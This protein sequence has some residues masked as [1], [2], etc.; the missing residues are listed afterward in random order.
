MN[1]RNVTLAAAMSAV[2]GFSP[3]AARAESTQGEIKWFGSIYAKFLDGNRRTESGLG[4]IV[5]SAFYNLRDERSTGLG[6]DVGAKVKLPTADEATASEDTPTA[7][8]APASEDAPAVAEAPVADES[9]AADETP[10]Q[11]PTAETPSADE[12]PESAPSS[13]EAASDEEA[14]GS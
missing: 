8:E 5:A 3:T 13:D 11:A 9:N 6:I 10:E 14:P 12:P 4:D 7:D 1:L 2:L